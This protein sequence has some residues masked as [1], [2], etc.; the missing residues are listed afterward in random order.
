MLVL[1]TFYQIPTD[2]KGIFVNGKGKV[3]FVTASTTDLSAF[4]IPRQFVLPTMKKLVK[5]CGEHPGKIYFSSGTKGYNGDIWLSARASNKDLCHQFL[6]S[7]SLRLGSVLKKYP[8]LW[9]LHY[10]AIGCYWLVFS[11]NGH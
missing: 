5:E 1:S 9:S 2:A 10:H 8:L 4:T 7:K 6:S 3:P 11:E